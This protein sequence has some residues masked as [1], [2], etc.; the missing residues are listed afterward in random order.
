[1]IAVRD[2]AHPRA[3]TARLAVFGAAEVE[4]AVIVDTMNGR[5]CVDLPAAIDTLAL[6]KLQRTGVS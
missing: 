1:M 5:V 3:W 2:D 6:L 4:L